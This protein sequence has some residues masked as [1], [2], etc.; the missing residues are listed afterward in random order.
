MFTII[1]DIH[2]SAEVCTAHDYYTVLDGIEDFLEVRYDM[3]IT[4]IKYFRWLH[5]CWRYNR[6]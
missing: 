4:I 6:Y 2:T 1:A 3:D 5:I